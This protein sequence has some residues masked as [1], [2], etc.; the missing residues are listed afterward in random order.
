MAKQVFVFSSKKL[1]ELA[2][3]EYIIAWCQENKGCGLGGA[4]GRSPVGVWAWVWDILGVKP[5]ARQAVVQQP[6]VFL[7]EYFGPYPS[8]HHWAWRN[9][10]VGTGGFGPEKVHVPRG[11]F[12]E[13]DRVVTS[14]RLDEILADDHFRDDWN[15]ETVPGEDENPPEIRIKDTAEHELLAEIRS[16]LHDY[17]TIARGFDQRLQLLGIG[18]GGAIDMDTDAGGHIGFVEYGAAARDTKTMLVRLAPSTIDANEDDFVL[19]NADGDASLEPSHYAV[20]QGI[21]TILSAGELL[22]M[23]WGESK[24]LAVERMFLG[25]PSEK[26]PAGWVQDHPNVTVF[27]DRGAIGDLDLD[28]LE[29]REWSVDFLDA[30]PRVLA[31]ST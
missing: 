12:F 15:A 7:D 8:Y 28:Q 31:P 30:V 17:D 21:S 16:T 29:K 22:L 25:A 2:V 10:R 20:T 13:N 24:Q 3:A 23:A 6:V 5:E 18:V 9:L 1:A 14:A 4:T 11:C 19:S 26:N 27:V